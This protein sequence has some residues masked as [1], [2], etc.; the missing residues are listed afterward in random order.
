MIP[1]IIH[2]TWKNNNVPGEYISY[3]QKVK[4]LHPGWEYRL[5]TDEDN[6][7]LVK[8]H[9][10]GF[11]KIYTELPK[12]IMRADAIRYLIMHHIGGVYLDLDY[13]ML[14]PFDLLDF[15][16]VLPLNRSIDFGDSFDSFGNC[17]FGSSPGCAFWKY[18]IEDLM[19]PRDYEAYFKTLK[20]K[21]YVSGNT[22]LEEAITGPAF[23]TRIFLEKKDSLSGYL[24]PPREMFHPVNSDRNRENIKLL[25]EGK[26]YGIHHCVGTWRNKSVFKKALL[27]IREKLIS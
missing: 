21:P 6:L 17:I 4:D 20:N 27:K 16:L 24:I 1:K 11:L 7:E 19:V 25:A 26:S 3:Q 14:K 23:L 13:E 12:N 2:Q 22:R 15:D 9:Y 18:V 8:H 5:W 10:P